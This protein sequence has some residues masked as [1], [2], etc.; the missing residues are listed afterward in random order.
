LQA[1]VLVQ[2]DVVR[3][4]LAVVRCGCHLDPV[5]VE[6]GPLSGAEPA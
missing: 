1:A 5:P 2:V 3:D 4:L 6:V